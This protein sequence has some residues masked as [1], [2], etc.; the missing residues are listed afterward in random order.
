[1]MHF[2]GSGNAC[3][4]PQQPCWHCSILAPPSH[5]L[6]LFKAAFLFSEAIHR[7]ICVLLWPDMLQP[8]LVSKIE[9]C[10][11]LL[12]ASDSCSWLYT[13]SVVAILILVQSS[14]HQLCTYR[15]ATHASSTNTE[16]LAVLTWLLCTSRLGTPRVFEA[17]Y[18]RLLCICL[19]REVCR[20]SRCYSKPGIEGP[21]AD[22]QP[23]ACSQKSA[24][25]V[26][27][28]ELQW[29]KSGSR[30]LQ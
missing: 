22:C 5:Q 20:S 25:L 11:V 6:L 29:S 7:P 15:Q 16:F 14:G 10:F 12:R 1:M 27:S 18:C 9:R 8:S 3:L 24:L 13:A 30:P 28:F 26:I 4:D 17:W 19:S 2:S 23:D 21:S